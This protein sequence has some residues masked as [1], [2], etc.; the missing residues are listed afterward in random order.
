MKF[1]SGLF[2]F[3]SCFVIVN[4][5]TE[6]SLPVDEQGKFIYYEVVNST[7]AKDLLKQR[8]INY[9]KKQNK[10]LKLNA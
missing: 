3:V 9:A 10:D 7:A 8:A 5:Q 4:A 6:Q 1:L 2:F